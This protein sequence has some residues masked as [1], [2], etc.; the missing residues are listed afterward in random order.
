MSY[1]AIKS[2]DYYPC[3]PKCHEREDGIDQKQVEG[4]MQTEF[5]CSLCYYI[6]RITIIPEG[7]VNA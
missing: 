1:V 4:T 2:E 5:I 7:R 3:C 6:W